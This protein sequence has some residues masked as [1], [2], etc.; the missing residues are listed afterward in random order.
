[1]QPLGSFPE[2][3]GA[4][5]IHYR[6]QNSSPIIIECVLKPEKIE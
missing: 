3:Y 5:N 1:V 6:V 4:P 2:F